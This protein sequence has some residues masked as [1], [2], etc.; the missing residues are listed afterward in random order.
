MEN[1]LNSFFNIQLVEM[2]KFMDIINIYFYMSK[3]RW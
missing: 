3:F 1:H 2:I